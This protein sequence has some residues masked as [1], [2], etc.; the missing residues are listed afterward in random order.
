MKHGSKT[1]SVALAVVVMTGCMTSSEPSVADAEEALNKALESHVSYA[2]EGTL[3]S[4]PSKERNEGYLTDFEL[5]QEKAGLLVRQEASKG[6]IR[7]DLTEE[8]KK[9]VRVFNGGFGRSHCFVWANVKVAKVETILENK[10]VKKAF[11]VSYTVKLEDIA[12][13]AKR[14]EEINKQFSTANATA[15]IQ[16]E[17]RGAMLVQNTAGEWVIQ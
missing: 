6:H 16:N 13:W 2:C 9:H 15:K 3:D 17:R 5:A 7:F 10:T 12:P 14:Y 11:E 1:I 8:G 4:F